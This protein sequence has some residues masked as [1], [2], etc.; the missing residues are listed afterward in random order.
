M[1]VEMAD[2]A[3]KEAE[4]TAKSGADKKQIVMEAVKAGCL[5][6]GIDMSAFVDQLS[7]Y[8]DQTI[9]FVNDMKSSKAAQ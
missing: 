6:A 2:K 9:V 1:I 3:M 7:D 4:K 5:A 8:I